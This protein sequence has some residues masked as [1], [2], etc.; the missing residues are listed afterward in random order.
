MSR[1]SL[2]TTI[3][4]MVGCF[5]FSVTW[6]A[7]AQQSVRRPAPVTGPWMNKALSAD[8]RADLLVKALTLDEK[9]SLVH[10]FRPAGAPGLIPEPT[11]KLGGAGFIPGIERLGIPDLQMADSAVGVTRGASHSRYSTA[12][13]S[14][15]A[16]SSS[17]DVESAYA[18]GALIGKELR[19]Q[20]YNMSLG[21]GV[22]ITREPRNGRNFEYMGEDP[23]LAG[24]MVGQLMK[25]MLSQH[26]ITD[27]K[28]FAVN[29]QETGRN[30]VNSI[31]DQRSL[32][33]TDLFAF[34]IGLHESHASAV[35]CSYN[36]VNG[37]WACENQYLLNDL[38][39]NTWGFKG[40]VLSDWGGTHTTVKAVLAGLDQEM[41]GNTYFGDAVK[42][43]IADGKVPMDRLND[44]VHRI[45]RSEIESGV[46]DDPPH[47]VVPE[48]FAGLSVARKV[49]EESIVLLK[50]QNGILPLNTAK[51]LHL[52]VI[53]SHADVG[54]LSGGGSA[55]VDPPGGN[56]VPPPP[57]AVTIGVA[58]S[59]TAR[60]AVWMPSSP[61]SAL[62]NELPHAQIDYDA[63]SDP[64]AAAR[65]AARADAA[66]VFV[67]QPMS[68]G[69]DGDL[70]LPEK[71]DALVE[72]VAAAN[73][74][75]IVVLE[76]G[77]Q[78]LMPWID[79]VDG[80]V[81]A[82]FP[83]I[84]GG[85][86][87]AE[88]LAG[89]VNPSGKL[90][91]TFPRSLTD[92]PHPKLFGADLAAEQARAMTTL[93]PGSEGRRAPL[94]P[95]D[96]TYEEGLLVGYKWYDAKGKAPLFSF[97][98]GLSYT[99]YSYARPRVT[100]TEGLEV[101]FEVKNTGNRAGAEVSE[102]YAT[103]PASTNEPPKRLIGW[104]RTELKSGESKIVT[105]TV[106]PHYLAVFDTVRSAWELAGGNYQIM[107]GGSSDALPLKQMVQ[108]KAAE[109]KPMP[110]E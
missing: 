72:A 59:F 70:S 67:N 34:E 64:A 39:K 54:V 40:W 89:S 48:V 96:A 18:Y 109:L 93:P 79:K 5:L 17:W 14:A 104:A 27:I 58:G 38:L 100:G 22:N 46:F 60:G 83:G 94:P 91:V 106:D 74:H 56:A 68:E 84:R 108:L 63:G 49:A 97:G 81:E 15:I 92:L 20:G 6:I 55:Q 4:R 1:D 62:R 77:G 13:P 65:T 12:L 80:V 82:W 26:M 21:G 36:K 24:N 35:M 30:I 7:A 61:L 110:A 105:V 76:T 28:H 37:D 45:L 42:Q 19:E 78:V 29:D 53:G 90:S 9:L 31:L 87:I 101:S 50:N 57:T 99:T 8:A 3:K 2:W 10:G 102:I 47:P 95:F 16:A 23:I 107:I 52:A 69:R 85:Q 98:H 32:R 33:E 41:P 43:A 71:Q 44:L 88:I 75:T 51:T 11:R 73:K 66:I 86:A 103:L 25:G